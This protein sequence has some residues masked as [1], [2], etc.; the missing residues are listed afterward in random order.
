MKKHIHF[1]EKL[2]ILLDT[3]FSILGFHFGIDPLLDIIPWLGDFIG[4]CLSSYI[5]W[6][7]FN[8]HVK[9]EDMW[10]MIMNIVIDYILGLVPV[11]GWLGDAWFHAN[12]MNMEI[13]KKY[14]PDDVIEGEVI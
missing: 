13:V 14:L 8:I 1:A 10:K 9:K 12:T 2:A 11:L 7:G 6:I 3:Q 5:L 4:L